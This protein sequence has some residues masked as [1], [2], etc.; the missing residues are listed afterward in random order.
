V[1]AAFY[2]KLIGVLRKKPHLCRVVQCLTKALPA[3]FM[4][5]YI[6]TA[7]ILTVQG[8]ERLWRFLAVP[9]LALGSCL[10]LRKAVN[11]PRPYEI[12]GFQPLISRD[13]K[14]QSCPSNHTV[15][16]F[17]ISLAFLYLSPYGGWVLIPA[18]LTALSRVVCG[19]HW[20]GD[21]LAGTALAVL[22]G[23][24]GFWII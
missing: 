5:A 15:S 20:L 4:M 10:V 19:V 24:F 8:D 1:T 9:A 16:A 3:F 13:K 21:V 23:I 2:E 6:L 12:G 22:I 17:V 18:V 7:A 14:G 11:R